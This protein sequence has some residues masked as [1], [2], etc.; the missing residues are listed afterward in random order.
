MKCMLVYCVL[1]CI[2]SD[3]HC[4]VIY[5]YIPDL[6]WCH[7]SFVHVSTLPWIN[8]LVW[9]LKESFNAIPIQYASKQRRKKRKRNKRIEEILEFN[10]SQ[11]VINSICLT[12]CG[13]RSAEYDHRGQQAAETQ[14]HE[15]H[16]THQETESLGFRKQVINGKYETQ[17]KVAPERHVMKMRADQS[18]HSWVSVEWLCLLT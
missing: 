1:N 11:T 12:S 2:R 7:D 10:R 3:G 14:E 9:K 5:L 13:W 8:T 17:R 18:L 6:I 15:G 16:D 4:S